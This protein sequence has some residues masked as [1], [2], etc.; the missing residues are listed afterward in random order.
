V[1]IA[2]DLS[3][4]LPEAEPEGLPRA[5]LRTMLAQ[6]RFSPQRELAEGTAVE[7]IHEQVEERY[8]R[9]LEEQQIGLGPGQVQSATIG[10]LTDLEGAWSIVLARDFLTLE[11][12]A[13]T[14]WA[15]VEERLSEALSALVAV[16]T[17]RVRERIGLRYVNEIRPESDEFSWGAYVNAQLLGLLATPLASSVRRGVAEVQL[18]F[19]PG[20]VVLRHG[21]LRS[22]DDVV[23]LLDVD[24]FS[25]EPQPFVVDETIELFRRYN[26]VAFRLFRWSVTDEYFEAMRGEA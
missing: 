12:T 1:N 8:P 22:E 18:Q 20:T 19:D 6:V 4:Y 26:D 13:Y 10:R 2:E 9:L 3:L 21:L 11:T 15:E 24:S 23:Y 25:D 7:R 17:P 5:P 16:V 14:R